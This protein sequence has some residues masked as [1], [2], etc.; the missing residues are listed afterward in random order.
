M[1]LID[2]EVYNNIKK[3]YETFEALVDTGATFCAVAKHIAEEMGY[4][5]R[6]KIHL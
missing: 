6:E 3:L 4:T 1:I 2:I 5:P